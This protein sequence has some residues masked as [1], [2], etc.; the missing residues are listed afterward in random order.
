MRMADE[1]HPRRPS[2]VYQAYAGPPQMYLLDHTHFVLKRSHLQGRRLLQLC[3]SH[4]S[5]HRLRRPC[6]RRDTNEASSPLVS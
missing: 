1:V 4:A 5:D 6:V 3:G 2:C